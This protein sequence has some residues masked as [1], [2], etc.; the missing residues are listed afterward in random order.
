MKNL[1]TYTEFVNESDKE[2]FDRMIQKTKDRLHVDLEDQHDNNFDLA[3]LKNR[4]QKSHDQAEDDM[5]SVKQKISDTKLKAGDFVIHKHRQS[6]GIGNI[7][8]IHP[9]NTH[10]DIHFVDGLKS[11]LADDKEQTKTDLHT[12]ELRHLMPVMGTQG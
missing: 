7:Q 8:K 3:D 6:M 11:S 4:I 10:A 12:M 2:S 1:K 9:N 5:E